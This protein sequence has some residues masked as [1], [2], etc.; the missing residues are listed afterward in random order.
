MDPETVKKELADREKELAD[1]EKELADN[2]KELV[3]KGA[4]TDG[5]EWKLLVAQQETLTARWKGK[6]GPFLPST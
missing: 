3:E 1:R 5:N 6:K 2:K 4:P